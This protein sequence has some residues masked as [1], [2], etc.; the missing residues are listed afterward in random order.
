MCLFTA[1][2]D[3]TPTPAHVQER[4]GAMETQRRQL[5]ET[6]GQWQRHGEQL[7]NVHK[8]VEEVNFGKFAKF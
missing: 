7:Q 1:P 6:H 3:L 8:C 2:P 4:L 5:H